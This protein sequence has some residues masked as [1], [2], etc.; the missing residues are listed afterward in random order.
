VEI[1]ENFTDFFKRKMFQHVAHV[2]FADRA[3]SKLIQR[4]SFR[5]EMNVRRLTRIDTDPSLNID[6]TSSEV[7]LQASITSSRINGLESV[8]APNVPT[9]SD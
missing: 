8:K 1:S 9:D 7:D 2:D 4:K 5:T 3:V 6:R